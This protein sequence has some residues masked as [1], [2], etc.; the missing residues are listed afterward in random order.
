MKALI[1]L[2]VLFAGAAAVAVLTHSYPGNVFIIIGDELRRVSLNTFILTTVVFVVVL[3]L[4]LS[5]LG[6]MVS[7]PGGMRRYGQRRRSAKVAD[8]LNEAGQA[9]FEGRFQKAQSEA[10]KV[11][12]NKECGDAAPLALMLAAYSAEQTNDDAAKQGYLQRLAALPESMQL[13]RYLLE[14]ESA[15]ERYDYE[16]AQISIDA[17]R[18]LNPGLTRLLQLELRMAV[19]QKDAMKVLRLTEQLGKAGALS[20]TELQQYQWVAYRQLLAQC[21]DAKALKICLK[22]IPEA[23]QKGGLSVEIAERFQQ[24][25]LYAQAAKWAKTHYPLNRDVALLNVLFE[26]SASL[27]DK[28]QQQAFEAADG[29]LKTYREDTDLLLAL[30]E[31]AYQ[32]QLWGKAQSYL[33]ASLSQHPSIQAHLALAKVF[34]ATEQKALAEQHQAAALALVEQAGSWDEA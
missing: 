13:S 28:E 1:W 10:E 30:G 34:K 31:A 17:A 33:E 6:R 18:K 9:F 7:I 27:S 29:W 16:A 23:D 5:L 32:R 8:A 19:D 22:R 2:V 11:L 20:A 14:A 24:L 15:L 4:L 12:K 25:G 26:S 21:H 3:Y